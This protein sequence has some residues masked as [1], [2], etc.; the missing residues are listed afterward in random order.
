MPVDPMKDKES[1][2]GLARS[3]VNL[4]SFRE[5]FQSHDFFI[6]LLDTPFELLR[7]RLQPSY[8]ANEKG[9]IVGFNATGNGPMTRDVYRRIDVP[10]ISWS[11]LKP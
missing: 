9:E 4:A 5:Q 1:A 2:T 11:K 6:F 3:F 7:A 8:I 10:N